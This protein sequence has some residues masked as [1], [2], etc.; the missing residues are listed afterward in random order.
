MRMASRWIVTCVIVL[1]LGVASRV[2]AHETDQHTLPLNRE[3][4]D[5]GDHITDIVYGAIERGVVKV[6]ARIDTWTKA[7]DTNSIKQLQTADE[8]AGAINREFPIALLLIEGLD[9]QGLSNK[10]RQ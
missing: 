4:V 10:S 8:I 5:L 3:F 2:R 6:N 7:G 9:K 1:T